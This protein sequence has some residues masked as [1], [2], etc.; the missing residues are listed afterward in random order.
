MTVMKPGTWCY[1]RLVLRD[2]ALLLPGDRFI[3]RMFS[4]VVT[5]GGGVVVDQGERR[6]RKGESIDARL[7][8]L[9]SADTAARIALLVRETGFGL[10]MAELV[11]RTGLRE[12][13]LAA[14][15]SRA[16]L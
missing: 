11:A 9:A 13:D 15:A 8:V 3:I 1:A 2:A 7:G 4:P 12:A 10:G 6:Y 14:A 5:I 16:P